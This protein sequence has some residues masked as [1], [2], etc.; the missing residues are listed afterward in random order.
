MRPEELPKTVRRPLILGEMIPREIPSAPQASAERRRAV[1]RVFLV[2]W[3]LYTVFWAP[4]ILREHYP[5][6]TLAEQGTL[7]VERY[8]GWT[9]DI[10]AGPEKGAFI[11]NNPGA[12]LAGAI[13]LVLLR[14]VLA[15]VDSWNRRQP[16][17]DHPEPG[18]GEV[19]WRAIRE[20]RGCYFLLIVFLTTAL[21]MAPATAGTLAYLCARLI[22]A[23]VPAA[24]ASLISILCGIGTPLLYR[25]GGLNHNLLVA[26]A[27][28]TAL[29]VLWDA[30]DRPLTAWRVLAA[31]LLSGYALLCDYSGI[32]VVA[33][34]ALYTWQRSAGKA[35]AGALAGFAGGT[36]PG[37]A[38]LLIYQAWAFGSFYHPS[39]HY[40]PATG[41]TAHGYRGFD[42]PSPS[43]AWALLTDPRFG[44]FAYC[45]AL[46]LAFPAPFLLRIRYKLP[47][48]ETR[49]IFTY[50]ALFL[51][52]CSANQ[53]SRLQPLTGFRYL[54]PVVPGLALLAIQAIQVLPRL[55]QA[56][57]AILSC[58]PMLILSASHEV[59][60]R[61]MLA[62]LWENKFEPLWLIRLGQSGTPTV[63]I[64]AAGWFAAM[65]L[66][67]VLFE[68]VTLFRAATAPTV[69]R[70]L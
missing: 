48:R 58:V 8:L 39:Q 57:L 32:V 38:I 61:H 52:F 22:E 21:V 42:W 64:H 37:V 17:P 60:V 46:M 13:P 55:A 34:V 31:G 68:V 12:S 19:F 1:L 11:N 53:Y 18:E 35:R 69:P 56:I 25:A 16:R 36:L 49:L 62:T 14:P 30:E 26:D 41:P 44:L 51:V 23:G 47:Q 33:I 65:A 20:G 63:W 66:I 24:S 70:R 43:L 15:R 9:D 7:N 28:F 6:I 27:G 54:V 40:M 45:P 29:L 4:Y 10:F 59:D 50:F 2:C 5:A 67:A 3:L